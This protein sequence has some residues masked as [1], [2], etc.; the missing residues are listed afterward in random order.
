VVGKRRP[1]IIALTDV[2]T[3]FSHA[4]IH[5]LASLAKLP[6]N[7]DLDAFA[8][9]V[10]GAACTYVR[11][12]TTLNDNELHAEVVALLKAAYG[13][14]YDDAARFREGLSQRAC[15]AFQIRGAGLAIE[16]PPVDAFRD[17]ARREAACDAIVRLGRAGGGNPQSHWRSL[18]FLPERRQRPLKREA[19]R[20]FVMWLSI[21][22]LDVT[23]AKPSL[24]ARHSDATREVGP[25]ASF[26]RECLRLVGAEHADAVGLITELHRRRREQAAKAQR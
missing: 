9:G 10:R 22:Y 14:Q 19:E 21:A 3:T 18:S 26:V 8:S 25:F 2:P 24:T 15:N 17:I 23:G 13:Q 16:L 12:A 20:N 6:P 1:V 4:R 11:E 5:E 7:A